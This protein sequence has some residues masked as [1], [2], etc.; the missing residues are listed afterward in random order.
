MNAD[1]QDFKYKELTERII[2]IFYKVYLNDA[3]NK[4]L[5]Q[6]HSRESRNLIWLTVVKQ[7][8]SAPCF[9]CFSHPFN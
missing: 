8:M 5:Q 4:K 9:F 1:F 3:K 2:K 6:C 7:N